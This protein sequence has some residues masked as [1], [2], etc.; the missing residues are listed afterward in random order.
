L[1]LPQFYRSAFLYNFEA[2]SDTLMSLNGVSIADLSRC[3]FAK[4]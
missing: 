4:Q 1:N 3:S 2:A